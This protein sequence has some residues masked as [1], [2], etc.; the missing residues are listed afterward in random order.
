MLMMKLYVRL[1]SNG[2]KRGRQSDT[3]T[4]IR[5]DRDYVNWIEF[6]PNLIKLQT[7]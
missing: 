5:E 7:S 4:D 3:E 1:D 2:Y 6:F